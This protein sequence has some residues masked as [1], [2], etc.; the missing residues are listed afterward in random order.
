MRHL[1]QNIKVNATSG[2]IDSQSD[3]DYRNDQGSK[4]QT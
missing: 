4:D 3:R 1:L 2:G